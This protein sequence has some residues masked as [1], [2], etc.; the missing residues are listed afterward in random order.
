MTTFTESVVHDSKKMLRF[1]SIRFIHLGYH[2]PR[3]DK[4][5]SG[6]YNRC[7]NVTDVISVNIDPTRVADTL[8]L[9]A[10]KVSR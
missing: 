3:S 9:A 4:T 1:N 10:K 8:K 7:R 6:G 2:P 5:P